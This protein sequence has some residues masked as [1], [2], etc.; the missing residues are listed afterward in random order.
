M[1]T[2][3]YKEK[4]LA[5][6]KRLESGLSN[7]GRKTGVPEDWEAVP[8]N[9]NIPRADVNET[10]DE[11]EGYETRIATTAVLEDRLAEINAALA[12]ME[13]NTYGMCAVCGNPIEEDR[14]AANPAA[15]TCKTHMGA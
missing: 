13:K 8:E 1:S 9:M 4:L 11:M 10:A 12:R 15:A 7:I 14:L 2:E 6:K 5:E 3:K